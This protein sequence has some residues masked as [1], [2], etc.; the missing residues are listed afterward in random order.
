MLTWLSLIGGLTTRPDLVVLTSSV[1]VCYLEIHTAVMVKMM[2]LSPLS[3]G[4]PVGLFVAGRLGVDDFSELDYR[5][6]LLPLKVH[7]TRN[8]LLAYSKELS[9]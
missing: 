8:F 4:A 5:P 9:K 1:G 2:G 6:A 7:M 3:E